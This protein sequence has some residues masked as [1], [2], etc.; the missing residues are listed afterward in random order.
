MNSPTSVLRILVVASCV[1]LTACFEIEGGPILAGGDEIPGLVG[2]METTFRTQPG[3]EMTEVDSDDGEF[4]KFFHALNGSYL[5]D[6]LDDDEYLVMSAIRIEEGVFVI[7]LTGLDNQLEASF[8]G[9]MMVDRSLD[10]PLFY[11]CLDVE[12]EDD[13][14]IA[15]AEPTGMS[16]SIEDISLDPQ[17]PDDL[18]IFM[19]N[20][21]N[22]TELS[23][24]RCSVLRAVK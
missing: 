18:V 8:A 20:V 11:L 19:T 22:T 5:I 6:D 4:I 12:A 16:L 21:W 9:I 24:W 15:A 3:G 10:A 14:Y 7:E 17:T 13:V 1:A 23:D 2:E